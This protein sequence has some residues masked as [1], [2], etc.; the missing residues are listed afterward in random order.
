MRED[1]VSGEA[2]AGA[3]EAAKREPLRCPGGVTPAERAEFKRMAAA[4]VDRP[5]NETHADLVLDLVRVNAAWREEWMRLKVEG[6]IV[7]GR[8]GR[9]RNPRFSALS[10]LANQ[11]SMLMAALGLNVK[12]GD[13]DLAS[14]PAL[15][16]KR[17][18]LVESVAG[19]LGDDTEG[20]LA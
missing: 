6:S 14:T 13:L 15:Q 18:A 11:R 1:R 19:T 17:R 10:I 8:Q 16:R 3:V 12:R 9:V 4:N 7:E 2:I 5:W 20:L